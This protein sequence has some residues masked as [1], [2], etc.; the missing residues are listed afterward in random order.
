MLLS[1]PSLTKVG[2]AESGLIGREGL[3]R[4]VAVV[5]AHAAHLLSVLVL[6]SLTIAVFPR[7]RPGFAFTAASLHIISPAGIFLS[8]PYAES[9]CALLTFA[10]VLLF[11]KSFSSTSDVTTARQ[12]ILLLLSGI[13]FG[14]ASAF[15]SNGVLSGLL[16]LEEAFRSLFRFVNRPS[17][18]TTRRLAL[19]GLG[20]LS[21]AAGFLL[22][23]YIAY[24]EYCGHSSP[25]ASRPWCDRTLP[26]I[27]NFVQDHYWYVFGQADATGE[28]LT[29]IRR[30]CGLFRYWTLSNLP[31]FILA[32]PMLAIMTISGIWGLT[33]NPDMGSVPVTEEKVTNELHP[34][35]TFPIIRNLAISQLMLTLVTFTT[36][37][38]QIISRISSAYP[39]WIWYLAVSLRDGKYVRSKYIV[40]FLVMYAIIQGGLFAS[41]LPPA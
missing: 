27:Y 2:L 1:A 9:S 19:T 40:Q 8:A 32:T 24:S 5:I 41:F 33:Y 34:T 15:R 39:V 11:S 36:A 20:G 18:P 28:M 12:D 23:Q 7:S 29:N 38:V 35:T 37:H 16:L 31:L 26:S 4:V 13:L 3:E 30:N 21:V 17:F 22:P 6:F 25:R 10:G 14:I